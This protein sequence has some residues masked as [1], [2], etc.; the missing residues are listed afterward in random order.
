MA[1]VT[2]DQMLDHF[3][4]FKRASFALISGKLADADAMI[5][6]D[7]P[8]PQREALVKYQAAALLALSPGGEFAR[9]DPT[10][11]SDGARSL[12]ERQLLALQRAQ[13]LPMV[14]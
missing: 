14:I 8:S 5:A 10:K 6:A 1:A 4:E 12:Y 2:V 11:E 13:Y 7:V 9:L 3:P